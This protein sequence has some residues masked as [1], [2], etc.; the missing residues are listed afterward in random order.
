MNLLSGL[1]AT[2]LMIMAFQITGGNAAKYFSA[3]LG[4][5]I[6]TTTISYLFILPALV[7]LRYS[8]P[9]VE[10]PYRVPGGLTGAWICS[11]LPAF[12]CL[13]ATVVLIWPGFGVTW[14]GAGGDPN[15]NLAALGFSHQRLSYELSQIVPLAAIVVIGVAFYLLGTKTRQQ[16]AA[17]PIAPVGDT[18]SPA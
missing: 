15:A 5:T 6:S 18:E 13:L 17:E 9:D 1:V 11:I 4:L 3:V 16:V 2:A 14:F 10:R 12:L 7:R 8:R